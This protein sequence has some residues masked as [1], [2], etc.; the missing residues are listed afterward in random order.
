MH[1]PLKLG[2]LKTNSMAVKNISHTISHFVSTT[3]T[4]ALK[5]YNA[6]FSLQCFKR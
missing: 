6:Q 3:C 4:V 2:N 1:F 5:W